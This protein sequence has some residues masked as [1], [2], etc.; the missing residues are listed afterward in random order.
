MCLDLHQ[1]VMSA[2]NLKGRSPDW[3]KLHPDFGSTWFAVED[4]GVEI[5]VEGEKLG[6]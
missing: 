2:P 5:D 4:N 3:R 6:G 1:K